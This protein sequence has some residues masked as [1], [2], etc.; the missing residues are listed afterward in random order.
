M[1]DEV[2]LK[3]YL[4]A[5]WKSR[6]LILFTAIICT[7]GGSLF[8]ITPQYESQQT[9]LILGS[10]TEEQR[11]T[12]KNLSEDPYIELQVANQLRA[13]NQLPT[14]Y[15]AGMLKRDVQ[16]NLEGNMIRII[17]KDTTPERAKAIARLWR[18]AIFQVVSSAFS[19]D[20]PA[21][22]LTENQLR[23]ARERYQKL[24]NDLEAF[25]A[26]GDIDKASQ[27]VR[28]LSDLI[29]SQR[30]IAFTR[31]NEYI[32][33]QNKI[34]LILRD[35]RMLRSRIQSEEE[36]A[37][38]ESMAAFLVRIYHSSIQEKPIFEIDSSFAKEI[39]VERDD[40]DRLIESLETEYDAISEE[41]ERLRSETA[42]EQLQGLLNQ[43]STAQSQL[44]ELTSYQKV[45]QSE[46]D[47][48]L[49]RILVLRQRLEELVTS[50]PYISLFVVTE[51][52]EN[53]LRS[54]QILWYA[55]MGG[56]T[57]II[58]SLMFVIGRELVNQLNLNNQ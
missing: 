16:V 25:I 23:E 34:D 2:D 4:Q 9:L 36:A 50:A 33:R 55:F 44:E 42:V 38:P 58:T 20:I 37:L 51:N 28:R 19:Q 11:T 47:L 24:Q 1:E 27:E 57:G 26:K 8:G 46:R 29:E 22:R 53:V 49:N 32:A 40:I 12:L 39:Q 5:I 43:L 21:L 6:L 56:L 17:S 3:S 7:V 41:I 13:T 52:E 48:V 18:D 31:L 10:L 14:N 35:I 15:E 45:L 54:N 30:N